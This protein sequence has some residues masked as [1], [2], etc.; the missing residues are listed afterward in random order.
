MTKCLSFVLALNRA[1]LNSLPSA[2]VCRKTPSVAALKAYDSIMEKNMLNSVAT[3]THP[4][5][6]PLWISNGSDVAPSLLTV[7][8]MLLW[9]EEITLSSFGS[10]FSPVY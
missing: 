7:P 8:F 9:K 10:Q 6:T 2:L 3:K 1:K 5:F 4:C